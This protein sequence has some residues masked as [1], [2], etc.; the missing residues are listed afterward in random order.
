MLDSL[1]PTT[2][3]P[4]RFLSLTSLLGIMSSAVLLA[5]L[6]SDGA[7]KRE[8]PGSLWNVMP[9]SVLPRWKRFPLSFGLL[10][11]GVSL[12]SLGDRQRL[13][14]CADTCHGLQFSGHAVVPSLYRDMA[15][16]E[17]FNSM[18]DAAYLIAFSVSIVF[19]VLGYLMFGNSVSSEVTRD[20]A[21]TPGFP[22]VLNKLAVWMVA[23]G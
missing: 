7:I 11:S 12:D 2:Y 22:V 4:L 13:E 15:H 9:T 17:H 20:L 23:V 5:V 1:L 3:L 16:P 21:S 6:I 10:M 19:A 8:A 14:Q 18:I